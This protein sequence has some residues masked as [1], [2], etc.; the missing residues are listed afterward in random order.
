MQDFL[1]VV[2]VGWSGGGRVLGP[3]S[4][5]CEEGVGE[6]VHMKGEVGKARLDIFGGLGDLTMAISTLTSYRMM[7]GARVFNTLSQVR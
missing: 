1:G 4:W 5:F 3:D 2:L 7:L 6:V